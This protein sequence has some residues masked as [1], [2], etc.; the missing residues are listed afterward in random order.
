ML[1]GLSRLEGEELNLKLESFEGG[2][3]TT[4]GLPAIQEELL[5]ALL[6]TGKPVVVVLMNGSPVS[7]L[8]AHEKATAL[9]I[10]AGY[11]GVEGATR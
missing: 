2:D 4:L 9:C 8:Q 6:A 7:S 5:A 3:R 11:P 10:L 1:L